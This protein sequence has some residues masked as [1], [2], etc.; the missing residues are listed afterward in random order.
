MIKK[1]KKISKK[2]PKK[3]DRIN[4]IGVKRIIFRLLLLCFTLAIFWIFIFSDYVKTKEV[5]VNT[6]K[7]DK[8]EIKKATLEFLEGEKLKIF[9][10]D[11]IVLLSQK[12]LERHLKEKFFDIKEINLIKNFPDKITLEIK[13]RGNVAVWKSGEDHFL[14]DDSGEIF[15]KV[16]SREIQNNEKIKDYLIIEENNFA[17]TKVGN[18]IGVGEIIDFSYKARDQIRSNSKLRTERLIKTPSRVSGE[19]RFKVSDGWKVY[20]NTGIPARDQVELLDQI[21]EKSISDRE[22][23]HLEYIDLRIKGKAIYKSDIKMDT[24]SSSE[25][26]DSDEEEE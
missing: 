24:G 15:K 19:A 3:T 18:R 16:N 20:F 5:Q 13:R 26:E 14:I 9:P 12:R 22:K 17:E 11:N 6:E 23:D 2:K 1:R 25:D 10:K 8:K 7:S 21:L 4:K